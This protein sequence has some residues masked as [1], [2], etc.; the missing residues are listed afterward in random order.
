MG[1]ILPKILIPGIFIS[2]VEF[3]K[4]PLLRSHSGANYGNQTS[5]S[6]TKMETTNLTKLFYMHSVPSLGEIYTAIC[7]L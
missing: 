3:F 7:S 1:V 2:A 5:T 6:Y 4:V